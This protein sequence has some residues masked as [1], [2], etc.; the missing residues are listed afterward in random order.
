VTDHRFTF[1]F[2]GIPTA[3]LRR[4]MAEILYSSLTGKAAPK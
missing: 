2:W 4:S 3:E 1:E